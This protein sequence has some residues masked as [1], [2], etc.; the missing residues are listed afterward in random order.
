MA[1][2]VVGE[3]APFAPPCLR[4]CE[5]GRWMYRFS[6]YLTLHRTQCLRAC[7]LACFLSFLLAGSLFSPPPPRFFPSSFLQLPFPSPPFVPLPYVSE[8]QASRRWLRLMLTLTRSRHSNLPTLRNSERAPFNAII[9]PP[10]NATGERER[11]RERKRKRERGGERGRKVVR[12]AS[13]NL[14][15]NWG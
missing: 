15:A 7:L 10:T 1:S 8:K 12:V 3:T 14:R 4:L 9:I 6:S 13:P 5:V 11:E 2:L